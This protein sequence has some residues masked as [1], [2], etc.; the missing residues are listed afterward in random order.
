MEFVRGETLRQLIRFG[1]IGTRD[2]L[3]YARQV[4]L[5]LDAAH[6][7]GIIHRDLKPDNVKVTPEGVVKVL[8]FGLAKASSG[9]DDATDVETMTLARDTRPGQVMGTTGY[10]SPE[11][12]RGQA[13]DRRTDVWAFGCVLFELFAGRSPFDAATASD[14]IAAVLEKDP[15]WEALPPATPARVRHLI[16]RCLE[17]DRRQR[18]RDI[19]D[20]L[21][22]LADDSAIR[23]A[24]FSGAGPQRSSRVSHTWRPLAFAFAAVAVLLA[25]ATVWL[26]SR[27]RSAAPSLITQPVRF[28][29]PP[30]PGAR[31]GSLISNIETTTIAFSP[32]GTRLAFI[33][34]PKDGPPVVFVR[35]L[36][37]ENGRAVQGSEGAVSVFWSPDGQSLG[38]FAGD[39]LKRID[40][41]GGAAV[42]ICDVPLLV[43]MYGTW[44]S[45]GDILFASVQGDGIFRVP[46]R[47][48]TAT[49]VIRPTG[50]R[51]RVLWP[52]YLPDGQRFL[53]MWMTTARTAKSSWSIVTARSGGSCRRCHCRYSSSP[54][55]FLLSVNRRSSPNASTSRPGGRLEN[56]SP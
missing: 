55:S 28:A 6:E 11:Q 39:K 8:D 56:R 2:A 43:G 30:P 40:S 34:T 36:D 50:V 38:F 10:M 47:G 41:A 45:S 31:F 1:T 20:A 32:D 54:T 4:A 52:H 16:A 19:G 29:L 12:A 27:N 33:A 5:A 13:V 44:G 46:A 26:W 21:P 18:L 35:G 17:K 53:F 23:A 3:G 49:P 7:K 42:S 24:S 22:D 25:G 14:T 15:D 48:G 37:D 9:E 51:R